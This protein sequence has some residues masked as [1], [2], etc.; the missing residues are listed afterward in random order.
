VSKRLTR[1]LNR[2]ELIDA[3]TALGVG[4]NEVNRLIREGEIKP[5]KFSEHGRKKYDWP[6]VKQSLGLVAPK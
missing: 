4:K 6:A 2:S 5:R 1:F 3:L